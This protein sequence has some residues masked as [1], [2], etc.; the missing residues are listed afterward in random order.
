MKFLV[1]E[2]VHHAIYL[3]LKNQG[4]DVTSAAQDYTSFMD[5]DILNIAFKQER[6]IITNDKDFG[7]LAYHQHLP[8]KG[9]ILFRLKSEKPE[10]KINRLTN[11]FQKN[12]DLSDSFTVITEDRIRIKEIN[13]RKN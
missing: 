9:I 8:H 10:S 6:I 3:F 12:L 13:N 11:L 2:N 4:F 7:F 5:K 1:D